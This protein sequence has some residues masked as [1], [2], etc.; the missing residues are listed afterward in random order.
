MLCIMKVEKTC[1]RQVR[2]FESDLERE[3][4]DLAWPYSAQNAG[5]ITLPRRKLAKDAVLPLKQD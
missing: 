3:G 1:Q 4:G 5:P 2:E